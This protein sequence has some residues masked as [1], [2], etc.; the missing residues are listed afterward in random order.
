M[1][2]FIEDQDDPGEKRGKWV[3]GVISIRSEAS[4]WPV[5]PEQIAAQ[6]FFLAAT[7]RR[8]TDPWCPMLNRSAIQSFVTAVLFLNKAVTSTFARSPFLVP[9][10][11][12]LSL[13]TPKASAQLD[14]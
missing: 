5:M 9:S 13:E 12:L 7:T 6:L 4:I 10:R 3:S 1:T 8:L 14:V 2:G 11:S